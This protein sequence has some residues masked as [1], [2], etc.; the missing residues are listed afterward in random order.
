MSVLGITEKKKKT[1]CN[2]KYEEAAGEQE[3]ESQEEVLK[4]GWS[5]R[6]F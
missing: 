3:E 2:A 1:R 5:G 6:V 4:E